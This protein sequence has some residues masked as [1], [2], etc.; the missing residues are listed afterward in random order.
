MEHDLFFSYSRA[1]SNRV[2]EI[3]GALREAGLK[4][5]FDEADIAT[6]ESITRGIE[7]GL[8]H[9]TAFLAYFSKTYPLRRACQWELTTAFLAAQID[10]DP[11][12][13]VLLINPE[14][15]AVHIHPV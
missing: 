9:S 13:R 4:V 7:I 11:R 14:S 15:G 2:R 5:W 8:A 1:D 6:F 10:G 3:V 12:R